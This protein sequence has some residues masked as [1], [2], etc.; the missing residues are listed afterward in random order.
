MAAQ[1]KD[2]PMFKKIVFFITLSCTS[3]FTVAEVS[4]HQFSLGIGTLYGNADMD[5]G[6]VIGVRYEYMSTYGLAP[7]VAIAPF[8]E[9]FSYKVGTSYYFSG[10]TFKPRISLSY[11]IIDNEYFSD[12]TS[13]GD[14]SSIT[15]T[16]ETKL[17]AGVSAG[18]GFIYKKFTFDLTSNQITDTLT[19]EDENMLIEKSFVSANFGYVY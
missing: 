10:D 5:I 17:Y 9:E 14:G 8:A 18:I 3:L 2:D 11:G 15:V 16:N 7:F 4:K 12:F 13:N 1:F 19:L 6:G